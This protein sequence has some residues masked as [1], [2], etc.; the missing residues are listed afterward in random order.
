MEL[1]DFPEKNVTYAAD[2]SQ[3]RPLP[4]CRFGGPEGRVVFCWSLTWRERLRLLWTGAVWHSVLTFNQPLQ[5]QLL[6]LDKAAL[7]QP[8][9]EAERAEAKQ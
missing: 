3:Y 4:A 5:P 6:S 1:V 8:W 9:S 2:Q 7:A